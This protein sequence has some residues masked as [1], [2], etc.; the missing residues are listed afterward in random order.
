MLRS[1]LEYIKTIDSQSEK[2]KGDEQLVSETWQH[3][4]LSLVAEYW[5]I[6]AS[7]LQQTAAGMFKAQVK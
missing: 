4:M 2:C 7:M 6:N 3:G 5:Q 1:I